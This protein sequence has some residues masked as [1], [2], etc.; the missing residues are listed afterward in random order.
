MSPTIQRSVS[1]KSFL[2][3][4]V[5]RSEKYGVWAS[6]KA[7]NAAR[8][9]NQLESGSVR[10]VCPLGEQ[11]QS[12][13]SE[14]ASRDALQLSTVAIPGNTRECWTVLDETAHTTTE[15]VVGEPVLEKLPEGKVDEFMD[16]VRESLSDSDA[17]LLAGSRPA[18]WPD[19]LSS[20]ICKLA[21]DQNKITLVDFWGDDLKRTLKICA[22]T[23][24]KIN[25]EEFCST[26]GGKGGVA[27]L[28]SALSTA[29]KK[30]DSIFIV[31]CGDKNTFAAQKGK[32]FE[33]DTEKALKIVNTT[34]CGDS[35][36]AGFLY[37][38][39]KTGDIQAALKKGTWCAARN[40]ENT[41]P[42]SLN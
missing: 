32:L 39:L 26:F 1:F 30:H 18:V 33:A 36:A 37:E 28:K 24:V 29:S 14:Y 3:N 21:V 10:V 31:T 16:A 13:F 11:N 41:C 42:G 5:N 25:E 9:L 12:R 20:K 35:F 4:K 40:A 6:G 15:L 2:L 7:V 8:V 17:L 38:F 22:P 34:A 27:G 19:D 23:I